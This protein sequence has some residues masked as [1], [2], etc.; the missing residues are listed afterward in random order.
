MTHVGHVV[1]D[2]PPPPPPPA[3][4]RVSGRERWTPVLVAIISTGIVFSLAAWW[5]TSS[6]Y[7]PAF[8]NS[9]FSWE[10]I[11]ASFP[12]V[13][14]G[15]WVNM[16]VWVLSGVIIVVVSLVVA[17]LRT[18]TGPVFAPFRVAAIVYIDLLRGLPALLMVLLLGLGVPALQLPGLPRS[19]LFWGSVALVASYSAY[20]AEVYRSGMEA[21]HDSQR[22][23]AKAL[24]LSQ[25]E[26]LRFAILPQA[27]R[28]VTPALLNLAVALQKDVAL[29][30][31]IGVREAVREARIYTAQTFNFSSLTGAAILFLLA[32]V[33]MARFADWYTRRD[34]ERRLQRTI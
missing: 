18:L 3:H 1:P 8:R 16:R 28:N 29:L 23:A 12:Q 14:K 13:L 15:F 31:I 19:G 27:V 6:Q 10:H 22:A 17:V 26:T 20:T 2:P 25:W 33:P 7:W 21:V 34:Q 5:I 24:G 4:Q 11:Q 9:F 30:S 32:S